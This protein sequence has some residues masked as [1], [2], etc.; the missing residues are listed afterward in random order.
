MMS[1]KKSKAL[2]SIIIAVIVILTV[3]TFAKFEVPG[4]KNGVYNYNSILGALTLDADLEES[5]C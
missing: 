4:I 5:A 3:M 2:L 1:K